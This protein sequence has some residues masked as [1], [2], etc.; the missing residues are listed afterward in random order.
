MYPKPLCFCTVSQLNEEN[1]I[2]ELQMREGEIDTQKKEGDI[3]KRKRILETK[4]K[5]CV[6][7]K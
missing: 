1:E 7:K 2:M 6:S 4:Q 3:K 5:Y